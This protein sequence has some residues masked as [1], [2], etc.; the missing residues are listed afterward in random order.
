MK[1]ELRRRLWPKGARK[2]LWALLDCARDPKSH[3]SLVSSKQL[4]SCLFAGKLPEVVEKV[5]PHLVQ[6][7]ADE[8]FNDYLLDSWGNSLCVYVECGKSLPEVRLHLRHFL[9]VTNSSGG[10]MLFRFYDPRVLRAYLPTCLPDELK[11]IFGPI[12]AFFMESRDGS[13]MLEF[14]LE[15]EKLVQKEFDLKAAQA[16]G[17]TAPS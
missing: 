17:S 8:K 16:N 14:R 5:A 11:T 10:K 7:Q 3:P 13:K 4:Y 15:G 1:A 2:D 6:L 9:T 12:D